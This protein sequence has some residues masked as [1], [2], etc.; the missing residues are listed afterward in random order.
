MNEEKLIQDFKLA[1]LNR[2]S[3]MGITPG[4]LGAMIKNADAKYEQLAEKR[5]F[6][7]DPTPLLKGALGATLLA[8]SAASGLGVGAGYFGEQILGDRDQDVSAAREQHRIDTLRRA[9]IRMNAESRV[10][11]ETKDD[12]KRK[13]QALRILSAV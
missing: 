11:R 6:S 3:K 8:I 12:R 2:I 13:P 5:A 7:L 1:T 4:E 10:A 9:M